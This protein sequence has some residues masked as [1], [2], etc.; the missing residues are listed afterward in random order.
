MNGGAGYVAGYKNQKWVGRKAAGKLCSSY[1]AETIA[2]FEA[3]KLI[4]EKKQKRQEFGQ[5]V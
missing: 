5:I 1:K 4:G 2:T 3:V